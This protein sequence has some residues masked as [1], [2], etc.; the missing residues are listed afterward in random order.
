MR[1]KHSINLNIYFAIYATRLHSSPGK[2]HHFL[3]NTSR[4]A[5]KQRSPWLRVRKMMRKISNYWAQTKWTIIRPVMMVVGIDTQWYCRG[6]FDMTC[7]QLYVAT[8]ALKSLLT[9]TQW[10]RLRCGEYVAADGELEGWSMFSRSFARSHPN[11][12][13]VLVESPRYVNHI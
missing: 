2:P 11:L 4:E 1:H 7:S 3:D 6:T 13:D 5:G 9:T 8:A 10:I 12:T